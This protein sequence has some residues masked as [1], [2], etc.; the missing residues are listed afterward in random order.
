VPLFLFVAWLTI[1]AAG[2]GG[3]G[4]DDGSPAGAA[5]KPDRGVEV[6]RG[7]RTEATTPAAPTHGETGDGVAAQDGVDRAG[8]AVAG[9]DPVRKRAGQRDGTGGVADGR[10]EAPSGRLSLT[11]G[12]DPGTKFSGACAAGD[13]ERT[14]EGRVPERYTVAPG[15][16]GIECEIRKESGALT[17]LVAS[18]GFRSVQRAGDGE[19][20]LE[21]AL[22][23]DLLSSG[24]QSP[25]YPDKNGRR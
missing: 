3:N 6:R 4:Q 5:T 19:S 13:E 8:N 12:G 10:G 21:F 17:V 20:T 11:L 22:S 25:A 24:I 14:I 9:A 15:D 1:L 16:A 7:E 18:Q 23:K 2:C